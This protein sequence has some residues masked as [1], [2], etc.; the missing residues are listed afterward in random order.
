M[1]KATPD[2][3]RPAGSNGPA[4]DDVPTVVVVGAG[5]SG[6][7]AAWALAGSP[8]RPRVVVLEGAARVGGKLALGEVGGLQVDVGAESLLARRPEALALAED[9]GL[10]DLLEHP[11]PVG[12]AIW[13]GGA[14]RPLPPRTLMGVP[15]G[16]QGLDGLLGPGEVATVRAEPSGS[17]TG[18]VGDVDVASFVASRVGQAVVD[19]LVEPLLGGVYAG[20]ADQL[21]LR[22]TMP[23]LWPAARDGRSVVATAAA[24]SSPAPPTDAS[25]RPVFAGIRGGV[26]RLPLALV[27][28]LRARGVE[29]VT[30][31]TVRRLERSVRG[32]RVVHGPTVAEQVVPA[33][34]VVLAVP[35]ASTSRLLADQAPTAAQAL[36]QVPYASMA[37]VTVVLPR[38]GTTELPGSG[39]LVPPGDGTRVKAATFSSTKWEWLDRAAGDRLVLRASVGRYGQADE[40]QHTDGEL[41]RAVLE[42]LRAVLG[43]LPEPLDAAVTRWGGGL[44]QYTVGHLDR[45]VTIR[46]DVAS[47]PAVAVCGAAYSGVGIPAC[48]ASGTAAADAVLAAL[49]PRRG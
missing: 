37:I 19:R 41:V 34:G 8:S 13:S 42:D 26:G 7:A 10:G 22:A 28:A 24:A 18:A 40:L 4:P 9:A 25:P 1:A 21:S 32:W 48:I 6:L 12:A 11:R 33:D 27:D 30:G 20:R 15:S 14:L 46:R 3:Q 16:D 31:A 35:A 5:I 36:A 23:A 43:P 39:F 17:W 29:V 47:L 49:A 2:P 38:A 44:P 45:V